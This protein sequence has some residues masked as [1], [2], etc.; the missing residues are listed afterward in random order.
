[1]NPTNAIVEENRLNTEH[2][3][4]PPVPVLV[5]VDAG[6][7]R[8]LTD[9]YVEYRQAL[10]VPMDP[11]KVLNLTGDVLAAVHRIITTPTGCFPGPDRSSVAG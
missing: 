11:V 8:E 1:M 3:P 9:R 6:G 5:A 10:S 7:M 2:T 4:E